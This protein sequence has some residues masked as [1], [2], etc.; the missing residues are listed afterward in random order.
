MIA[1]EEESRPGNTGA[2]NATPNQNTEKLMQKS[3]TTEI[4]TE[5]IRFMIKNLP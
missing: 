5:S 3:A 4:K 2:T 1:L